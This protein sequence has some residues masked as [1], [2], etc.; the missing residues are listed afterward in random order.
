MVCVI[1]LVDRLSSIPILHN[2]TFVVLYTLIY[3]VWIADGVLKHSQLKMWGHIDKGVCP[4][5]RKEKGESH[6]LQCEGRRV[7]RDRWLER[8][9]T[10]IRVH[11]E[12]GIKK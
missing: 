7:W 10:S 4:V 2:C 6:I 9:F 8:K 11:P 12:I 3:E 1:L 5:C